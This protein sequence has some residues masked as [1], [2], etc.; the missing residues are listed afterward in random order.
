MIEDDSG[1][2]AGVMSDDAWV[3]VVVLGDA[4]GW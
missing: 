3:V 4:S 1:L 2:V